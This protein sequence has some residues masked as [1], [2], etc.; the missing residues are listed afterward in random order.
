MIWFNAEAIFGIEY[1]KIWCS[2]SSNRTRRFEIIHWFN[3]LH[4]FDP[5]QSFRRKLRTS[6]Y[7]SLGSYLPTSERCWRGEFVKMKIRN[8]QSLLVCPIIIKRVSSTEADWIFGWRSRL[9]SQILSWCLAFTHHTWWCVFWYIRD[10]RIGLLRIKCWRRHRWICKNVSRK[11]CVSQI[12]G[13]PWL[14]LGIPRERLRIPQRSR[15]NASWLGTWDS[16]LPTDSAS[17]KSLESYINL[18]SFCSSWI[19][20]VSS[21]AVSWFSI[22]LLLE[23]CRL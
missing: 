22:N 13:G 3:H 15:N 19:L 10:P 6:T 14:R 4:F 12:P 8:L 20:A 7:L 16:P 23:M 11:P 21:R 2:N 18:T 5:M 1:F 9:A 17:I